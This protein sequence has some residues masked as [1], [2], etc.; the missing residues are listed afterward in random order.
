MLREHS[1]QLGVLRAR[2]ERAAQ[3]RASVIVDS[4]AA[5]RAFAMDRSHSRGVWIL[6]LAC[7]LLGGCGG[8]EYARVPAAGVQRN[9]PLSLRVTYGVGGALSVA[10][11]GAGSARL[12]LVPALAGQGRLRTLRER[13]P[14]SLVAGV[15]RQRLNEGLTVWYRATARGLEQ[16]FTVASRPRGPGASLVIALDERG[17]FRASLVAPTAVLLTTRDG[18]RG[19]RYGGLRAR[20]AGGRTL[21]AHLALRG[22]QIRIVVDDRHATFPLTIDPQLQPAGTTTSTGSF[23][24]LASGALV[25][26]EQTS[27]AGGTY[28]A[29]W[30]GGDVTVSKGGQ[31]I[32]TTQGT[33]GGFS[34]DE[35]AFVAE[36][37]SGST[38]SVR[39]FDLNGPSPSTAVWNGG[40]TVTSDELV[41]SPSGH[42]LLYPY[43]TSDGY[44][45]FEA[46][47]ATATS[48][49]S[50]VFTANPFQTGGA[51]PG[52]SGDASF[53][54]A[55]YGFGPDD[56]RFVYG[57]TT[58]AGNQVTWVWTDLAAAA[59]AA[60]YQDANL[61]VTS[62]Y[63][64]FTP[65]GNGL[66]IVNSSGQDNVA[67]D[68]FDSASGQAL[69][70]ASGQ[71]TSPVSLTATN[72]SFVATINGVDSTLAPNTC[73]VGGGGGGGGG[74][75]PQASFD[76]PTQI[77]PAYPASFTDTSTDPGGTIASW[78]WDFGDGATSS[79]E[80]PTHTYTDAKGGTYTV[81]L[82]VTDSVSGASDTTSQQVTVPADAPPIASFSYSPD[83]A[84]RGGQ[85]TLTST[86]T[87]PDGV[88]DI[89]STTWSLGNYGGASGPTATISAACPPVEVQLTVTDKAGLS[90]T[91][92]QK[93][94][95]QPDGVTTI[96]VPAGA[97][98]ADALTGACPGDTLKLAAGTY[99][100]GVELDGV[101]LIGAG[102]GQTII[103][104]PS[105]GVVLTLQPG[106]DGSGQD[107]VPSLSDVSITGG[108]LGIY[109]SGDE[110]SGT[111]TSTF[112]SVEV[113]G[114]GT[115]GAQ[116]QGGIADGVPDGGIY[117]YQDTDLIVKNS[118]IHDN[119]GDSGGVTAA[120]I[121]GQVLDSTVYDNSGGSGVTIGE[122]SGE[123]D[124]NQVYGNQ[125]G[126]ILVSDGNADVVDNRVTQNAGGAISLHNSSALVGGDLV[127]HNTGGGVLWDGSGEQIN[128]V[129]DTVVDNEGG[130]M[131]PPAQWTGQLWLS[132][133]I[134]GGNGTDIP[135]D[136]V[137]CGYSHDLIGTLPAF[138]DAQ[139]HLAP[140]SAAI[141][142]G[143]NAL[144]PAALATDLDGN[145]RISD[146]NGDGSAVVDLGYAELP[147]GG[148]AAPT[149]DPIPAACDPGLNDDE[150]DY[151]LGPGVTLSTEHGAAPS[152]SAPLQVSVTAPATITGNGG[153]AFSEIHMVNRLLEPGPALGKWTVSTS[154]GP[155]GTTSDPFQLTFSLDQSLIGSTDPKH[156]TISLNG[157][158]VPAC[159][160]AGASPDPCVSRASALQSGG[161]Q[162]DVRATSP[163][164][165]DWTFGTDLSNMPPLASYAVSTNGPSVALDASASLDPD[166]TVASYR[167][168]F[169]DGSTGDGVTAGH[170]YSEPGTYTITLTVTDD[171]GA[172][173]TTSRQVIVQGGA[174]STPSAPSGVTAAAGVSAATVDW[175]P[176]STQ[177]A[178]AIASYEITPHDLTTHRDGAPAQASAVATSYTFT[179][180][181]DGDEYTFSVAATNAA[182]Q[183]GPAATSNPVVPV[184]VATSAA[185]HGT[186]TSQSGTAGAQVGTPGQPGS[187][188][189][190]AT[191]AGT[192][193]VATYP[194]SPLAGFTGG[195][196]FDVS[197]APGSSFSSLQF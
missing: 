76:A 6:A 2:I 173:A 91:V 158:P 86:S 82:T 167:W 15:R 53:N 112:D 84:Q 73:A 74:G 14:A 85:L 12:R 125:N 154:A 123:V 63:V 83:P 36:S 117:A 120:L 128:A 138:A 195:A 174:P 116:I 77:K 180:L 55:S 119:A 133:M 23:A 130:G 137:L 115:A 81:T 27:S 11:V 96:D 176:P 142:A 57:Y 194:S 150:Y 28:T 56:S 87:D 1:L 99:Q 47:D 16:G 177:G 20:D 62:S 105:D 43:T 22:G 185:D 88:G 95:L 66:A 178:G 65:C 183:T 189:A 135:V 94:A 157:T 7:A 144:V 114:N 192:V 60:S 41:F 72:S 68:L 129:N 162:I 89:A 143:S 10:P 44:I 159:A 107:V 80:N 151:K 118:A 166:G 160:G 171:G 33:V 169:G 45:H 100:G 126:G 106:L 13:G 111:A 29:S 24:K 39:L 156:L 67:V 5:W 40:A 61:T 152:S 165:D 19:I 101:N 188:T 182:G 32:L 170:T 140:G 51:P 92:D 191:G 64:Q 97:S 155:A 79:Q 187:V 110:G 141:D 134:L 168:D 75:T 38:T 197:L 148:G 104:G 90:D 161:A 17:P 153:Q 3:A 103:Q 78:H 34:P 26:G 59:P 69:G 18:S 147:G 52:A 49:Q 108:G 132:N 48:S 172:T 139:Y 42:Y 9:A 127:A 181:T 70:S 71:T 124:G 131:V 93:I 184:V 163:Q 121:D 113:Y 186:S 30:S 190:T 146:G 21:P 193:S 109:S 4:G 98:L 35:G 145:P 149:A 37:M 58:T 8:A 25:S 50:A 54:S 164:S 179:G 136:T 31:V 122:A 196:W 46:A 102:Q 175:Q